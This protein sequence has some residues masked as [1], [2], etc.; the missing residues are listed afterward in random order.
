M[1]MKI[2]LIDDDEF[3]LDLYERVF[4]LDKHEVKKA[5]DGVEGLEILN[6]VKFVPDVIILDLAMPRMD[7]FE[8][9][10]NLKSSDKFKSIPVIILTNQF[11]RDSRQKAL[12][13]GAAMYL[14]KSEHNPEEVVKQAAS[15]LN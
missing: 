8:F 11:G 14:V 3:I 15:L 2:L 1:L 7:G 5:H 6:N 4:K 13:L 10:A 9:L 12:D